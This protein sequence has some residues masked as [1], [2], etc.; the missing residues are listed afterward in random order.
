LFSELLVLS[1]TIKSET[2]KQS[3]CDFIANNL[4]NIMETSGWSEIK[5]KQAD[6]IDIILKSCLLLR[7]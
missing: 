2:L 5:A 6:L 7:K 1:D 3:T 4:G